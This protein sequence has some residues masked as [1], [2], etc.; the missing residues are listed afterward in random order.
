LRRAVPVGHH[1]RVRWDAL[2]ASRST[3]RI[4]VAP[5]RGSPSRRTVRSNVLNDQVAV[6]AA[7][8]SGRRCAVAT[9]RAR[10]VAS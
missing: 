2:P 9:I 10:A 7:F 1:G 5:T 4:V 6:P 8:R 3:R